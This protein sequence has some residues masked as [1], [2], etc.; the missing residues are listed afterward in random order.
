MKN[1]KIDQFYCIRGIWCIMPPDPVFALEPY[2]IRTVEI[3][4]PYPNP[5]PNMLIKIRNI[6]FHL[7]ILDPDPNLCVYTESG[8]ELGAS[9]SQ[10][11][12]TEVRC[13]EPVI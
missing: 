4:D 9:K 11:L 10:L 5:N 13:R 7:R 12:S 1:I 2:W 3:P 6:V 8:S